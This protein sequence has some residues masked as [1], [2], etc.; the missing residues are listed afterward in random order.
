MA[1]KG[2]TIMPSSVFDNTPAF[3]SAVT[4]PC[5]ALTS[6]STRRATS[7]MDM[8]PAPVIAFSSFQR[9]PDS[10]LNNN[11]GD[12]KLMRGAEVLA[13][14]RNSPSARF[15]PFHAWV[16]SPS[17]SARGRISIVTVFISPPLHILKK[18]RHQFIDR[19]EAVFHFPAA[20]MLV[21]AL[22]RLVVVAQHAHS[23]A[24]EC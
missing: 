16:K 9:L 13:V 18:I 1:S 20:H 4:S 14:P 5:T 22:T 12:S 3:S 23:R 24:Y 8:A 7:R 2:K 6:R 15:P 17:V 19:N 10:A 11:S 21:V